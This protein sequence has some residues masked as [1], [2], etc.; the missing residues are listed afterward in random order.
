MLLVGTLGGALVGCTVGQGEGWV[1]SHELAVEDCWHGDFDLQP[2]FFAAVPYRNTQQ[3]R[4]QHGSDM[5]EVSDGVAILVQDTAT[6]R[7]HLL[8]QQLRVGVAPELWTEISP[9][10]QPGAP[11]LVNLALYLQFSC[12]NQNVVLY[13]IDGVIVF[14]ALFSG[15]PHESEGAEKLTEARFSVQVA[16]P[17]HAIPGTTE[18]PEQYVSD[19]EG[20]FRFHFLRGQP[21]QPFP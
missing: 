3:I 9:G 10:S 14:D 6:V 19:L 20:Y 11:P 12:H 21:G 2:D 8:G 1:R 7:Q 4:I 13:A 16:D 17:R 15:D 5:Q 18:V